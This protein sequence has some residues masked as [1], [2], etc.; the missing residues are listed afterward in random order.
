MEQIIARQ[1]TQVTKQAVMMEQFVLTV[2]IATALAAVKAQL[3]LAV[4]MAYATG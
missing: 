2:I 4:R 1:R 3:F